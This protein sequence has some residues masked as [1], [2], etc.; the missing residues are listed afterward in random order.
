MR[1]PLDNLVPL[2]CSPARSE[3]ERAPSRR[4]TR[5]AARRELGAAAVL[6]VVRAVELLPLAEAD[7]RRWLT[8]QGLVRDLAG[9]RVVIWG[10]VLDALRRGPPV[11][12]AEPE[13]ARGEPRGTA[14]L[15]RVRLRPV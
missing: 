3:P 1:R 2:P 6:P 8:E 5:A 7:A 11:E 9:R 4:G 10:D 13:P 14:R 15:P 12:G